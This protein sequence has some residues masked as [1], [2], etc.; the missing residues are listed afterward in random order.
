MKIESNGKTYDIWF[1]K[2]T[3]VKGKAIKEYEVCIFKD[4]NCLW[5]LGI[6]QGKDEHSALQNAIQ[7]VEP[8]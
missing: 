5:R 6:F 2:K 1:V 3:R 4:D 7:C 8:N